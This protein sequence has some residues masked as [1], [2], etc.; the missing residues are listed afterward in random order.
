MRIRPVV[1]E[2][3]HAD[4]QTDGQ[5]DMTKLAVALYTFANAPKNSFCLDSWDLA[6]IVTEVLIAATS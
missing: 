3:F 4:P 5:T 6:P 1:A 2:L